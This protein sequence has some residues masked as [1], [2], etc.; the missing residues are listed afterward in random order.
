MF[1]VLGSAVMLGMLAV[2]A[3]II[4]LFIVMVISIKRI[5]VSQQEIVKSNNEIAKQLANIAIE[6]RNREK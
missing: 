2:Y 6:I 4:C 5:S 3:L 1:S